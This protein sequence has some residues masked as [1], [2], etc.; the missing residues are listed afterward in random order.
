MEVRLAFDRPTSAGY[1][2]NRLARLLATNLAARIRP[3]GISPAQFSVLVELALT[4]GLT[5]R[6]LARRLDVEQAT[7]AQTLSRMRRDGQVRVE[8]HETDAR[9]RRIFLTDQ[10]RAV[11][12]DAMT[13]ASEVNADALAFLPPHERERFV[14]DMKRVVDHLHALAHGR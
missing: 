6:D 14:R 4:G 12:D 11:L 10:A 7:M 3:L 1:L 2:A 9:A 13:A 8:P 5:Q